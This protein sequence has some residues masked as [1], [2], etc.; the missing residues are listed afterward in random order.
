VTRPGTAVSAKT[1]QGLRANSLAALVILLIEY[2]LG[3]WVN[4]YGQL[5]ASDHGANVA[6]GFG[7]AVADGP[8]GLS[9]H[10]VLGAV[11]IVSAVTAVVRSFRTRRLVLI[12]ATIVGLVAVAAAALSG[13]GFVGDGSNAASM[14]M[15]IAAGVA[16]GAYALVLFLPA[17]ASAVSRS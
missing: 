15:G 9:I 13:A 8:A 16:I 2:G 1:V 11:L 10:A 17:G 6:A 4:L 3:V 7:R 14:S 5:P 12:S